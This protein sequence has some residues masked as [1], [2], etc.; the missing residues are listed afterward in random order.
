ML[1]KL[2]LIIKVLLY[3]L[4]IVQNSTYSSHILK[5]DFQILSESAIHDWFVVRHVYCFD[6]LHKHLLM[7]GI[8]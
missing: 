2:E 7:H 6:T 3:W 8:I 1:I 5:T 4:T